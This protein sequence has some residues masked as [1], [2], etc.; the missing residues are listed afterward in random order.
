MSGNFRTKRLPRTAIEENTIAYFRTAEGTRPDLRLV[1]F[2]DRRIIVKDFNRSDR[3]FRAIVGPVLIRRELGALRI[4]DGLP[5]IPRLVGEV[6][7]YALAM[8]HIPGRSLDRVEPGTLPQEF[9][10]N[11]LQVVDQMHARG[12]AH[13]DL[14]SRGNV[15]LGDDGKPY[16]VDF[17]ACV[18]RG[19]GL[20]PF[21][22]WVF[23]QFVLADRNAV[24]LIKQ[25]LSPELLTDEDR[26]Q[27][28]QELPYE[29]PAKFIGQNVR[30]LTRILLT[31]TRRSW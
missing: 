13:C 27:L 18:F 17:A 6:D 28:A 31:R 14:R 12:I 7:R 11:L 1:Q 24:L 15:V 10:D 2:E 25:R 19:R 21:I 16:I 20:N 23:E 26:S 29:R 8:E 4:L 30:K 9:Y 22:R 3:L 5:G